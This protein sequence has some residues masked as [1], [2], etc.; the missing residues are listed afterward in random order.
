MRSRLRTDQLKA[1][2]HSRWPAL[3]GGLGLGAAFFY[4]FDPSQ[5]HR[6]RVLSRD[7]ALKAA[8]A[9]RRG[10]R[11]FERNLPNRAQGLLA[12]FRAD[13]SASTPDDEIVGERVRAAIGRVCSHVGAVEVTVQG[14]T[15]RLSGPI[16]EREH[17]RV[18]RTAGGVRGVR[19][20]EDELQRHARPE[21]IPGLQ[22]GSS[23]AATHEAPR[24]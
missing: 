3:L 12:R 7:K 21:G 20:I 17:G 16:L 9:G 8:R 5:G 18:L 11:R 6:R 2:A 24:T 10:L 19:A 15:V 14:G 23:G 1:R 4:L 13:L 22:Q